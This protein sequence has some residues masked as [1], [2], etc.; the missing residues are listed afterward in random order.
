MAQWRVLSSL[1]RK[2]CGQWPENPISVNPTFKHFQC[3]LHSYLERH[4]NDEYE[5]DNHI[6]YRGLLVQLL[7]GFYTYE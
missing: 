5:Y 4:H 1:G 6:T 7:K 2:Y 3:T